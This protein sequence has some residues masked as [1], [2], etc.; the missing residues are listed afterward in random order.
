[1][2]KAFRGQ[3]N[4]IVQQTSSLIE[5]KTVETEQVLNGLIRV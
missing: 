5:A 3:A 2:P 1:M 4:M